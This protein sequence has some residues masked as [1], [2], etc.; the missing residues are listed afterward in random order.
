LDFKVNVHLPSNCAAASAPPPERMTVAAA[1]NVQICR[2]F[3]KF[4]GLLDAIFRLIE[5]HRN[6]IPL[7]M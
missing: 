2:R 7:N 5:A 1:A 6:D 4:L 3:I